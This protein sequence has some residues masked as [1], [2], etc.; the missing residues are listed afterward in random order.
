MSVSAF[1]TARYKPIGFEIAL[2]ALHMFN[3]LEQEI[4]TSNRDVCVVHG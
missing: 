2:L 4:Y 1:G 3:T